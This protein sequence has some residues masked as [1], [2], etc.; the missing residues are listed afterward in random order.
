VFTFYSLVKALATYGKKA[1][2]YAW[3]HKGAILKLIEQHT[4]VGRLVT[5]VLDRI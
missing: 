2:A 4:T 1:V 5:Y 3:D